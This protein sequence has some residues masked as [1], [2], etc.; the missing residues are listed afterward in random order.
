MC[1]LLP[2]GL[3]GSAAAFG[4][5]ALATAGMI[6]TGSLF[7][8]TQPATGGAFGASQPASGGLFGTPQSA[9]ASGL[10]FTLPC[11]T[12]RYCIVMPLSCDPPA[13]EPLGTGQ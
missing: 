3:F 11:M 9:P 10:P 13:V 4:Q 7:G 5:S 2:A 1:G 6:G 12:L 8:S